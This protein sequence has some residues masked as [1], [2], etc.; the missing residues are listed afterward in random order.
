[1]EGVMLHNGDEVTT[2]KDISV[3]LQNQISENRVDVD[4]LSEKLDNLGS[5]QEEIG[6]RY[7]KTFL[8]SNVS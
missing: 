1:M 8:S 7:D 4:A 5:G 2:A 3:H 6:K